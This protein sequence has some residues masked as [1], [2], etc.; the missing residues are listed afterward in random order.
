MF[1]PN[2]HARQTV[3]LAGGEELVRRSVR[4][5]LQRTGYRIL[6]ATTGEEALALCEE[7][8]GSIDLL[9]TDVLLPRLTGREL[10]RRASRRRPDMKV[11]Y[12]TNFDRDEA[13]RTGLVAPDASLLHKRFVIRDLS[14]RSQSAFAAAA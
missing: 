2:V 3:L 1:E 7:H 12:L 9:V 5:M 11:V 14:A 8:N 4:A 6:E 13:I 10:A